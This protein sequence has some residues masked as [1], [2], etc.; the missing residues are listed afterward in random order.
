MPN[1]PIGYLLE[2]PPKVLVTQTQLRA[3]K[4]VQQKALCHNCPIP[5]TRRRKKMNLWFRYKTS[6]FTVN[7][8]DN[9]TPK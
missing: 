1:R 8:A 4:L 9:Y 2:G 6:N 5:S 3:T 7:W